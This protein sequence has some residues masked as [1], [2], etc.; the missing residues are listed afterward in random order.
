MRNQEWIRRP[1]TIAALGMI[2]IATVAL[3]NTDQTQ[4][5]GLDSL[6]LASQEF[7]ADDPKNGIVLPDGIWFWP[8]KGV[9]GE[10][11]SC[12]T[13]ILEINKPWIS[14]RSAKSNMLNCVYK[15]ECKKVW[16]SSKLKRT[17]DPHSQQSGDK[18]PEKELDKRQFYLNWDKAQLFAKFFG[19][20]NRHSPTAVLTEWVPPVDPTG[21]ALPITDT[22]ASAE[23][24]VMMILMSSSHSSPGRPIPSW[25][26]FNP[27]DAA[28]YTSAAVAREGP[29]NATVLVSPQETCVMQVRS[30]LAPL[31]F[32]RPRA[33]RSRAPTMASAPHEMEGHDGAPRARRSSRPLCSS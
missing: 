31:L 30:A 18:D 25:L 15:K 1:V 4:W 19:A 10:C 29:H 7:I 33:S 23:K 2:A 6:L 21:H 5:P 27:V 24:C 12:L 16:A 22:T 13:S 20:P 28:P 17:D 9:G 26:Y 14:R 3:I 32:P 8:A 11:N